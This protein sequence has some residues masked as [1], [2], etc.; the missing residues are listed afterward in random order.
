MWKNKDIKTDNLSVFVVGR[1]ILS[2]KKSS[3]VNTLIKVGGQTIHVHEGKTKSTKQLRES[4]NIITFE[5]WSEN[6][7][8]KSKYEID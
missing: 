4:D 2:N 8:I 1:I 7:K 6:L 3:R 5:M